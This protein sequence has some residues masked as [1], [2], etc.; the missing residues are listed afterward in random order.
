LGVLDADLQHPPEIMAAMFRHARDTGADVVVA[1]RYVSGARHPG[2]SAWRAFVSQATRRLAQ[3]LLRAAR[4]T[5]DPLSGCFLVRRAVVQDAALR[6][7]GFKILLE[8]LVRGRYTQV[9]EVPYVFVERGAGHT[10]AGV[11]QGLRLFQHITM[12][13]AS[14]PED[15]R[16]WKFLLVGASGV[17]VN[18]VVFWV[19][20]QALG[21]HYLYGGVVAGLISTCTNFLLNNRFTWADRRERGGG[22]F[23]LR[24]GKYYVA[25]GGGY[26]V[27]LG[28]LWGLTQ[29]GLVKMLANLLAVGFGGLF[30]YAVHNVWTWR[31]HEDRNAE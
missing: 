21:V 24:L 17:V 3:V 19:L 22:V 28:L 18:M 16:L 29:V 14:S 7:V 1:S 11:R 30:N 9:A 13:A 10:K 4:R 8:I 26:L 15:A 23:A 12:L 27:Y 5:S 20:A 2:L 25:T 6:P 31:R